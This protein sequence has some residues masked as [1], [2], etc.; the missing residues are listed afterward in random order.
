MRAI[1]R[2]AYRLTFGSSGQGSF[3]CSRQDVVVSEKRL[4]AGARAITFGFQP[5]SASDTGPRQSYLRGRLLAQAPI[6]KF[7]HGYSVRP[8]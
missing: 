1:V 6:P 2:T 8:A 5:V 4:G 3:F 7:L